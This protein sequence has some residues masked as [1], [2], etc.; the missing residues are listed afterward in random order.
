MDPIL[1]WNEVALEVHRRDFSFALDANGKEIGPQHGGPTR[2]SRALAIVHCA[3][4][5]AWNGSSGTA[6]SYLS[7]KG[8]TPPAVI[9][10][11]SVDAAVAGA[12]T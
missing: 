7:S 10:G 12:A 4:Y 2:T 1:Y 5:D 8:V 3:M 6:N 9:S 11:S